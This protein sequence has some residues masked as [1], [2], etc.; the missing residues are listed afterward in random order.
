MMFHCFLT[1]FNGILAMLTSSSYIVTHY[2][3][4]IYTVSPFTFT[5]YTFNFNTVTFMIYR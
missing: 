2:I 3:V 4:N 1:Q 5:L